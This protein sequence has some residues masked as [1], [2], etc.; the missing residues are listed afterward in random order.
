MRFIKK[1]I[2]FDCAVDFLKY[3]KAN[4]Y[5][6]QKRDWNKL[7][8]IITCLCTVTVL[9]IRLVKHRDIKQNVC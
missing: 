9:L 4:L 7:K 1:V 6:T 8:A 2:A 3:C 5:K